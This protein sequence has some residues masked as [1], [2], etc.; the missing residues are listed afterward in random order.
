M[1]QQKTRLSR[2]ELMIQQKLE[3]FRRRTREETSVA[4]QLHGS[5]HDE[6][7]RAPTNGQ[8]DDDDALFVSLEPQQNDAFASEQRGLD[9]SSYS[10][11][12]SHQ[13]FSSVDFASFRLQP[14]A[15]SQHSHLYGQAPSAYPDFPQYGLCPAMTPSRSDISSLGASTGFASS[16]SSHQPYSTRQPYSSATYDTQQPYTGPRQP[17]SF[18]VGSGNALPTTLQVSNPSP[19]SA[20]VTEL[21]LPAPNVQDNTTEATETIDQCT[22]AISAN[23]AL[24]VKKGV[25]DCRNPFA[26]VYDTRAKQKSAARIP[27]LQRKALSVK[28]RAEISRSNSDA[29]Y[30]LNLFKRS[31]NAAP[32]ELEGL[33]NN[34]RE[35]LHMIQFSST[36]AESEHVLTKFLDDRTGLPAI[37]NSRVAPWDIKL[38]AEMLLIRWKRGDV[39]PDLDRGLLVRRTEGKDANGPGGVSRSIDPQFAFRR[40]SGFIGEGHLRNG[41]WWPWQIAA[42]RD[43]AHGDSE[44]GISGHDS[45]AVSI[46]LSSSGKGRSYADI[47]QGD[48]ISYCGTRGKDKQVSAGT[49]LML[50]SAKRST[51]I[52]VLRSAKLPS[53]NPYRPASGLR[54]D[55]LYIIVGK[56][57]IDEE[58]MLYRFELERCKDQTPIRYQGK[59]AR[60]TAQEQ[61]EFRRIQNYMATTKPRPEKKRR[62]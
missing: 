39:T 40:Q 27:L 46:V 28:R 55:G 17:S 50:E 38:D 4:S 58:S 44:A 22:C 3:E 30:V 20:N 24:A 42:V 6:A 15:A 37:V 9:C 23:C 14:N 21:A 48:K 19:I 25:R 34:I 36:P 5:A 54:Y 47:D 62:K 60:P 31:V 53:I 56:E 35:R 61:E 52:R 1:E 33:F 26:P 57:I 43:G 49:Q 29:L 10:Q 13:T 51:P 16:P 12:L 18:H 8:A 2:F 59:E 11:P 45:L 7:S 41:Q 32:H